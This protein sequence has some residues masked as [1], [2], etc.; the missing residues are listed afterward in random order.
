MHHL[1]PADLATAL[2]EISTARLSSYK[3]FFSPS[4]D[5]ELYGLYCWND[6][7]SS[8]YMRLMGILEIILRNRFH[9]VLSQYAWNPHNSHGIQDSNDWYMRFYK[10]FTGGKS[11]SDR[12]LKK[13]IGNAAA[14]ASANKVIAGMTYG[15]WPHVLDKSADN[16][17]NPVPW[18]TLI[19]A[20]FPD[21]H[22]RA[23]TY[24][25]VLL[26]QDALFARL[27]LVG[28]LRNRVA[29]FEPLWKFSEELSETRD[30]PSQ[31]KTIVGAAPATVS[32]SLQRLLLS[33]QKTTQLLRW[34]SKGRAADY[35]ES[36]NHQSLRWLMT[37]EGLHSFSTLQG[38]EKVRLSSLTKGW[39][40]KDEL[41][42]R[43]FALITHKKKPVGRYYCEP[44]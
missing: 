37:N 36:E 27:D 43:K 21:H 33:Y 16:T 11:I 23:A 29:H 24:W 28:D 5:A 35:M 9:T 2:G 18:G 40:L 30:R 42:A 6:A 38:H 44:F 19:P 31:P 10:P 14:P 17:G 8:R 25:R 41:R 1:L 12:N 26:H 13:K 4:S 20:I 32:K 15:F 7:V 22:Q 3:S 34:L 39:G